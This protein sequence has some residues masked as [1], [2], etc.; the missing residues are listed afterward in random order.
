MKLLPNVTTTSYPRS[1]DA[2]C[3]ACGALPL[4]TLLRLFRCSPK[5]IVCILAVCRCACG[6][7]ECCGLVDA[8]SAQRAKRDAGTHKVQRERRAVHVNCIVQP[9]NLRSCVTNSEAMFMHS[10]CN[11]H[12]RMRSA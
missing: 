5:G 12:A 4:S 10:V 1:I 8:C 7:F 6:A 2:G 11:A 3:A 9:C